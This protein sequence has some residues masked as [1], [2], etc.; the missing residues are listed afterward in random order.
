MVKLQMIVHLFISFLTVYTA[1]GIMLPIF[2]LIWIFG[3]F[4]HRFGARNSIFE[5][6]QHFFVS[7]GKYFVFVLRKWGPEEDPSF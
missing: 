4:I 1:K 2:Q 3:N 7:I 5:E 6:L